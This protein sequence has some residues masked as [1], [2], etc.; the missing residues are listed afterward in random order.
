MIPKADLPILSFLSLKA[1][2]AWLKTYHARSDGI[3]LQFHKKH[4]GKPSITY[5]EALDG[6]LCYGWIDGQLKPLDSASW[7]RKFTPRRQRSGWSKR[8]TEHVARLT[9]AGKM[10]PAGLR[11]V[12]AAKADGRWE[13]A[14]SAPSGMEVPADFLAAVARHK[15]AQRCFATLS[16]ANKY[17]IAYRLET[18]VKPETRERR[19]ATMLAMLKKGESFHPLR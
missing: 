4:S 8:N 1:W 15:Q 2:E 5:V 13:R 6:A 16:K 14:Y 7:L 12:E 9:A 3:W 19:F 10:K 11:Q 17:A 18:A